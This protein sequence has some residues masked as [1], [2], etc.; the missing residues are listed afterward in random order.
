MKKLNYFYFVLLLFF[1][2]SQAQIVNI[3]DANFKAALVNANPDNYTAYGESGG[4]VVIDTNGDGEIQ[5][6][7]ALMIYRL[8]LTIFDISDMTGI[9]AFANLVFLDCS[10]NDSLYSLDLSGNLNLTKLNCGN[11]HLTNLN[12]SQ[13]LLL[14]SLNCSQNNLTQIDL[15]NNINLNY[16]LLAQNNLTQIDLSNTPL[17]ESFNCSGNNLS[18]LNVSAN[19]LLEFLNCSFNNLQTLNVSANSNLYSLYCKENNLSELILNGADNL[20]SVDCDYNNLTQID[21]SGNPKLSSLT[22][23]ANFLTSLDFS[24]NPEMDYLYF[25][26]STVFYDYNPI[27]YINIKNGSNLL[28]LDEFYIPENCYVCV[29]EDDIGDYDLNQLP[30]GVVVSTYCSYPPGGIFNTIIGEINFD[31]ENNGN[32]NQS[33]PN[34][35]INITNGTESGY[36]FTN[37]EGEYKFYVP[38]GNF[39]L[40]PELIENANL[41]T[42]LPETANLNFPNLDESTQIQ[43]F[44]I[45]PIGN[46]SDVEIIVT[47][48]LP[49]RPGF[50]ATYEILYKNKGNQIVS[51]NIELEFDEN[52]LDFLNS[53]I[54]PDNQSSG[55]LNYNFLN[56]NPFE[57]RTIE[58]SFEVNAPTDTPPVNIGD[59]ILSF[60][61]KINIGDDENQEDNIFE[62]NQEVVGSYDPNDILCLEGESV[63]P[64]MIGKTLHYRIRFENTGTYPAERVVVAMPI[65]I[66]DYDVSS[67]QL[68]TTF[69][70]VQARILNNTAEFFFEEINLQPSEQG[71]I[72]FSVN[73][74]DSLTTGDSVMSYAD[75][76]FDYNY[77]V[78]TNEAETIF[79]LMGTEDMNLNNQVSIYPNPTKDKF[80]IQSEDKIQSIEIYDVNGRLMQVTKLNSNQAVQDI[81]KLPKGVYMLKIQS[82]KSTIKYKL[83]KK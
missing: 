83:I 14:E 23:E 51:G 52:T 37:N 10:N 29:D 21:F 2:F 25:Y 67:F 18:E 55:L 5:V 8:Q 49:A 57:N 6:S 35:Q 78:T 27:T 68:L 48:L 17:L 13:N 3:P 26:S 4:A 70:N 32:C 82:E 34:L 45:S 30:E 81:S 43:N 74:L 28:Y 59:D 44:C 80:T 40:T 9:E 61:S 38:E 22:C 64:E 53:T 1:G 63:S 66:E 12:I 7:E 41:F 15:S 60:S 54:T 76:Y 77:P 46:H 42:I 39:T 19:T 31:L 24:N 79:E 58:L 56:L 47:P 62:L 69:H 36:T 11:N 33:V 16:V 65:D 20:Y 72:I 50:E 75:I 71:Y 73:S